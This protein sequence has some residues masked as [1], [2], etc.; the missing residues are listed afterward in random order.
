MYVGIMEQVGRRQKE[1]AMQD[2]PHEA[3]LVQA[4]PMMMM[5]KFYVKLPQEFLW[6]LQGRQYR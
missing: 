2:R 4:A 5:F 1:V 6:M 3:T